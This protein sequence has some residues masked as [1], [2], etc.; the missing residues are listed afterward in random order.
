MYESEKTM[1]INI[2][3]ETNYLIE[4]NE[5]KLLN[6]IAEKTEE[7]LQIAKDKVVSIIFVDSA[8]IHEINR[9]Y[10]QIDRSTDVISFALNDT[11][12]GYENMELDVELGDIF[13]NVDA[14][15]SQA[16]Q[17]QHSE[18]RELAFLFGHGLL[19]LLGYDHQNEDEEKE[20]FQLQEAIIDEVIP[21]I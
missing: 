6:Q 1:E 12:N 14:I 11:A 17:Y 18:H 3:N 16:Q 20:M 9:D 2:I 15:Q 8:K 21:R 10:R 4:E 19:H 5:E 7:V 13:I